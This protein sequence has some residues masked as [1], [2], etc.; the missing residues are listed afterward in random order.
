[1]H[2][3]LAVYRSLLKLIYNINNFNEIDLDSKPFLEYQRRKFSKSFL[4]RQLK[5]RKTLEILKSTEID[6]FFFQEAD[7]QIIEE[8]GK[9]FDNFHLVDRIHANCTSIIF[10][11]KDIC[12][13]IKDFRLANE[14]FCKEYYKRTG[15]NP[16]IDLYW[17]DDTVFQV[18]THHILISAH[19]TSKK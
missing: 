9:K 14:H 1:M 11:R 7:I 18:L 19:L 15:S 8:I 3:D 5:E 16:E 10:F 4:S 6:I 12:P 2:F 17:N 13:E